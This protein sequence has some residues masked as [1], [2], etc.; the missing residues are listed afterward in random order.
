MIEGIIGNL[1]AA[2]I[3]F[4][5]GMIAQWAT[6]LF[7]TRHIRKIWRSFVAKGGR[8]YVVLTDKNGERTRS[9]RKISITDVKAY[10]RLYEV[11]RALGGVPNLVAGSTVTFENVSRDPL[12]SLGGPLANGVTKSILAKL[13]DRI[14][15]KFVPDGEQSYF[16]FGGSRFQSE[17]NEAGKVVTDFGLLVTVRDIESHHSQPVVA[18]FGLHGHGTEQI[19]SALLDYT[20]LVEN[21]KPY[22]E[23]GYFALMKFDFEDHILVQKQIISFDGIG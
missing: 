6:G 10:A 23:T 18:M 4:L 13:G 3:V 11:L 2:L 22:V 14:P 17:I 7:K 19:V 5:L 1:I 15:V 16:E 21:I 8:V 20:K 12:V 9:P